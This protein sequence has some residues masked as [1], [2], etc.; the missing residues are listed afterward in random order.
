MRGARPEEKVRLSRRLH[1]IKGKGG[2]LGPQAITLGRGVLL[3]PS[4]Q[5]AVVQEALDDAGASY[6]IIPVWREA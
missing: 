4:M 1:G 5:Q 3:I 6:D 2:I